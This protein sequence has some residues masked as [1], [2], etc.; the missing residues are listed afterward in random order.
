M[1]R[2]QKPPTLDEARRGV[3][4]ACWAHDS[5]AT[6]RAVA[7][8]ETAVRDDERTRIAA[9]IRARAI[10]STAAIVREIADFILS[11]KD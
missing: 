11:R 6:K 2:Q 8:L 1:P 5:E 3:V 10:P 7:A 9:R 4:D